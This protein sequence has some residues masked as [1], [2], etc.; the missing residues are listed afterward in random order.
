MD[1]REWVSHARG[2]YPTQNTSRMGTA[3]VMQEKKGH[4]K[5]SNR[6][7]KYGKKERGHELL[8]YTRLKGL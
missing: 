4:K 2:V 3:R 6:I 7:M 8:L 5:H 1:C